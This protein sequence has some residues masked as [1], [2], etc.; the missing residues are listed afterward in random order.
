MPFM[1]AFYALEDYKK[2]SAKYFIRL[3]EHLNPNKNPDETQ[4]QQD[5]PLDE[6]YIFKLFYNNKRGLIK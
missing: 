2:K 1:N 3:E 6:Q 5:D 4:V